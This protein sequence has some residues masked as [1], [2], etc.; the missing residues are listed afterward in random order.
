MGVV[1]GYSRL[2]SQVADLARAVDKICKD[3]ESDQINGV[4]TR[5]AIASIQADLAWIKLHI[6]QAPPVWP[7]RPPEITGGK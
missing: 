7:Y 3:R 2:V 1:Y 6:T 5:V 4:G